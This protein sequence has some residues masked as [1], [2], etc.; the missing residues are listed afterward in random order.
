M[1]P[2]PERSPFGRRRY[3]FN[4]CSRSDFVRSPVCWSVVTMM[5]RSATVTRSSETD[6][7]LLERL[8]A[9]HDDVHPEAVHR[10]RALETTVQVIERSDI[11]HRHRRDAV[12]ALAQGLMEQAGLLRP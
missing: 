8:E 7:I 2:L 4:V 9:V 3:L 10:Y 6:V 11:A 1:S 5:Q 12:E